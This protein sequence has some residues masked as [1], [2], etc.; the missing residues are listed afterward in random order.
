MR[1]ASQEAE[2]ALMCPPLMW[3]RASR[4]VDLKGDDAG[5]M[6]MGFELCGS[7]PRGRGSAISGFLFRN[8]RATCYPPKLE[9]VIR[10][11]FRLLKRCQGGINLQH[12]A[13]G[14][15]PPPF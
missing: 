11:I 10:K 7:G 1:D 9:K 14:S 13:S 6:N 3:G 5:L 2:Q 4:E 8:F 12:L 15:T